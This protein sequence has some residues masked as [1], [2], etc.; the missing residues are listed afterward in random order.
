MAVTELKGLGALLKEAITEESTAAVAEALADASSKHEQQLVQLREEL[1]PPEAPEVPSA[2]AE[3]NTSPT[4]EPAPEPPT[5]SAEG[6]LRLM[7]LAYFSP[8]SAKLSP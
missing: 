8:V 7:Q 5:T 4:R 1:K 2:E 3:T 6:G